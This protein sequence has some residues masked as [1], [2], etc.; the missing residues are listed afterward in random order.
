L[1]FVSLPRLFERQVA[2][3]PEA[4]AVRFGSTLVSYQ[5]LDARANRLAHLLGARGV[6]RESTVAILLDRSIDLVVAILAV[7]KAGG[8]YVPLDVRHGVARTRTVLA[9]TATR[10]VITDG[11]TELPSIAGVDVISVAEADGTGNP[12]VPNVRLEPDQLAYVMYTS[13]STGRP[14]GIAVTHRAIA[15]FAADRCWRGGTHE[16]V[17]LHSAHTFDLSTYELWVPLLSGGQVVIAPP[18]ILT[19]TE[20]A[21]LSSAGAVTGMSV[22]AGLFAVLAEESPDC[23]TGVREVWTGG[24]AVSPAAV[25]KVLAACPGLNVV[26]GYGPTETTVFTTFHRIRSHRPGDPVPIGRPMDDTRVQVLDDRLRPVTRGELYIAGTGLA[27]GYLRQPALTAERFV[28][29]PF[30]PPGSRMYRSGDLVEWT[31]DGALE[32]LGRTDDQVKIRGFRIE[33]A[34]VETV[35]RTHPSVGQAAVVVREDRPGDKRLVGYLV[36][37]TASES[38]ADSAAEEQVAEWQEIYDSL[39]GEAASAEPGGDFSGWQSSYDGR[40]IPLAEMREWQDA[41]VARVRELRPRRLLEIGVGS[42]LLLS[43]LAPDCEQYWGTDFSAPVI[44]ALSEQVRRDAVLAGSVVLRTQPADVTA[45]LPAGWFDTIVLNSVIQYFPNAAYLIDVLDKAMNLLAPGGAL[46][47]GDVRNLNLLRYFHTE[48]RLRRG[49]LEVA[50][51]ELRAVIDRHL[52][53]EQELVVAPDFFALLPAKLPRISGVDIRIKR[54]QHHNELSRYR[55]DVVLRDSPGRCQQPPPCLRWGHEVADLAALADHLAEHRPERLRMLAVPNGR[56]AHVVRAAQF[57]AEGG[58]ID[59][60]RQALDVSDAPDPEAFHGIGKQFGYRVVATWTSGASDGSVDVL[61]TQHDDEWL[62]PAGHGQRSGAHLTN[63]PGSARVSG[64]LIASVRSHLTELLPDYMMPSAIVVLDSLPLSTN[65][66]VDRRALPAPEVGAG[67]SGRAA[68]TPDEGRLCSLFAEVLGVAEVTIDDNFFDLGGHSLSATR[69][70]SRVRATLGRDLPVGAVFEAPTVAGLMAW[71]GGLGVTR[72][73]LARVEHSGIVPLSY[74]QQRLWFL[75]RMEGPSATYNVPLAHRVS[76]QLDLTA[77]TAALRDVVDRHES[78]RTVFTETDGVPHQV[79][80]DTIS[81]EPVVTETS[82]AELDRAL[83]TVST[84]A[85]DLGTEPPIRAELLTLG[86]DDQVLLLVVHHIACDGW[87]LSRLWS[88]LAIAYAARHAG[89]APDWEPLPVRYSDFTLWQRRLL[90]D[91]GVAARQLEFWTE[92]LS[93]LPEQLALSSDRPRPPVASYRG[94]TVRFE[95]PAQLHQALTRLAQDGNAT[96][97]MVLHAAFVALLTRLGAGTD[98]PIGSPI[99]NRTED[100]LEGLVGFFVNTLV[101]RTDTSGDPSFGDLVGRVRELDLAAYEHQDVPFERLVETLRPARSLAHSPLFQVMLVLQNAPGGDLRLPG[102]RTAPMPVDTGTCRFDLVLSLSERHATDGTPAGIDGVAEYSTDLFDRGTAEALVGRFHR[103]LNFVA[104]DPDLPIGMIDIMD[105]RERQR[106]LVEWNETQRTV[107]DL[108]L[109]SL[110]EAQVGRTPEATA[111]VFGADR[112]TYREL[113]SRANRLA[114]HLTRHGADVERYVAIALSRSSDLVVAVLAVLKSGAAYLPVDPDHPRGRVE[115]ALHEAEPV[116]VITPELLTDPEI[117]SFADTDIGRPLSVQHPAYVIYTSGSTGRPKGVVVTH[118]GLSSLVAAQLERFGVTAHSRIL[119]FATPSFD[120]AVWELWGALLTGATLVLAP[121]HRLAPGDGLAELVAEHGVTHA[122]LPPAVLATMATDDLHPVSWLITSGE[123]VSA[124]L[125][126]RWSVGRTLINGY[127]PTETT[128]CATLSGP[129]SDERVPP[130]GR[131]TVNARAYVLDRRL[132]PLPPG[133]PG[134]LYMA[135]PGLARGYLNQPGATAERFL[136]NPYGPPGSRMYRTGDLVRWTRSGELE[137]VGRADDQVKIRGFRVEPAEVESAITRF[138]GVARAVVAA[139]QDKIGKR[140]VGYVA[141]AG[142]D[143]VAL[144]AYLADV[145]PDYLVPATVVPLDELP[146]TTTGK[147]D[148]LALPAPDF[149]ALS[150][151]RDPRTVLERTLCAVFADVLGVPRVTIDDSFFDLGGHSLLTARLTSEIRR[152]L[153]V[154]LPVRALFEKQTVAEL[155]RAIESAEVPEAPLAGLPS[156]VPDLAAEPGLDHR[157]TLI[158]SQPARPEHSRVLLTGA[159]G[160]LGAFLLRELLDQTN[161]DVYC[162][163]RAASARQAAGRI[164]QAL[165]QYRLWDATS[166]ARIVP[167]TGD[168]ELPLLGLVPAR[169]DE[170]GELLDVI[171][172]NG[173]RVS[174]VEPYHRL[175]PANVLGTQE[176][177]RL[178]ARS[179]VTPVHYVSTAAVVVG[180]GDNPDPIR[181]DHSV[182]PNSLLPSGY[183]ATKWMAERLVW[184]AAGRGLPVTVHRPGRIGGDTA[185]GMGATNDAFWHLIR[186]MLLLGA[187]PD[188]VHRDSPVIDL[189]PVDQVAR[190]VVHLAQRPESVARAHHLTC[191]EP[192]SFGA[193]LYRLRATGYRLRGVPHHEWGELLDSR[194]GAATGTDES[195]LAAAT[196][197]GD[198]LPSLLRLSRL[199]FDQS[200]TRAGLV[201]SGVPLPGVDSDLVGRYIEW[202]VDSGFFPAPDRDPVSAEQRRWKGMTL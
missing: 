116:L 1:V 42:G 143:P 120:G 168:L 12:G 36:P 34:E 73:R 127:G 144:R 156:G 89:R 173:A 147:V 102:L 90:D 44:E 186:A 174:A 184:T 166:S 95:L 145:L 54:G 30:G 5:E 19:G 25:G 164:R 159:T 58:P 3:A 7:L 2:L 179:R 202:F 130:I 137:F 157:V 18:G 46:F 91:T 178:A 193:L 32:F 86:P 113:N 8:A 66:K 132:L 139:H 180:M 81:L 133:V 106:V 142:V 93:G 183:V 163:V 199:R 196:L 43:R 128:V 165:T 154:S 101:L 4:A 92:A 151:G 190:A 82:E 129:L 69:L 170:L 98:I 50:A 135:G 24:E 47:V 33:P 138:P 59:L 84:R 117:A 201:G 68:R 119:Q 198:T 172:H 57:V 9:E 189:V 39:Y 140:L 80:L 41:T 146:L 26:N 118:A 99:A 13:G 23:F 38:T 191:A 171:Y 28:A 124:E 40:P 197:L 53:T 71:L 122:T 21:A 6:V 175:R 76:G 85:F 64:A 105:A 111:V 10:V 20:F 29:D 88:D 27:R 72:P 185:T 15:S 52:A 141:P 107:P 109:P 63:N 22:T 96:L 149:T 75:H 16:R 45:G 48:V 158:D 97:F 114:R 153:G 49:G 74:A 123:A 160:F 56:V 79:V 150:S 35:L 14:K 177:L 131:P 181:E 87:S 103:L 100:T 161:A 152:R 125:V 77:L 67:G 194:A 195:D 83:R 104:A 108:P 182:E 60:A 126:R 192:F 70:V 155:A 112:M 31:P 121:T 61:F 169:F 188:I 115:S 62:P 176:V 200:N 162:L 136:A 94:D 37:A 55:Y 110:F 65:G 11:R 17:L 134:E 51:S 78:L 167:I 148:R 187:T